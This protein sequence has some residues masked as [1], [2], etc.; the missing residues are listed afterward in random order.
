MAGLDSLNVVTKSVYCGGPAVSLGAWLMP[1]RAS[2]KRRSLTTSVSPVGGDGDP[3]TGEGGVVGRLQFSGPL[4]AS[5]VSVPPWPQLDGRTVFGTFRGRTAVALACRALGLGPGDEVLVP[6]YN[7]GTEVDALL[8]AGVTPVAFRVSGQCENDL[9]DLTARKTSR[10]RAVYV[11]HYFG[12]EQPLEEL[13]RWCNQHGFWLIEDCALALFSSGPSGNIGRVGDAAIYSLPKSLGLAHGGLLSLRFAPAERLP[14]LKS[15]GV[16]VLLDEIRCSARDSIYRTLESVG[17]YGTLASVRARRRCHPLS[18]AGLNSLP[19]MPASYYFQPG[20]DA[21]RAC[22]PRTLAIASF[23][24]W[25]DIVRA[26]R[27]NYS[28]LAAAFEGHANMQTLFPALPAGVCP[29][30]MPLL[31]PERDSCAQRLQA[32]GIAAIPWWAGFHR[33]LF[34]WDGFPEACA[35][36]RRMVSVP[37]HQNLEEHQIDSMA[38]IVADTLNRNGLAGGTTPEDRWTGLSSQPVQHR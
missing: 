33:G 6:A 28:R 9:N 35:L 7:C 10:T 17:L 5:C 11:I 37:V 12:W 22:H 14:R 16:G 24:P 32:Q 3:R 18:D 21:G 2:R 1:S 31:V 19:D 8:C 36:K 13:R 26:R 25:K 30:S 29:L 27:E 15:S 34:D 23:L 4:G 20:E 38:A